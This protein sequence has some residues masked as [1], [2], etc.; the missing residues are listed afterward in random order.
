[1][2]DAWIVIPSAN[3]ESIADRSQSAQRRCRGTLDG[4]ARRIRAGERT[5]ARADRKH[6]LFGKRSPHVYRFP[7]A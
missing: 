6:V 5:C 2:V 3:G 4:T 7:G 1:M